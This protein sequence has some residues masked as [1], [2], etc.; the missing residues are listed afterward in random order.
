MDDRKLRRKY[1]F[2]GEGVG[3]CHEGC[4]T[5]LGGRS[6]AYNSA[7]GGYAATAQVL[8][9]MGEL[10]GGRELFLRNARWRSGGFDEEESGQ[11][12]SGQWREGENER[13][14]GAKPKWEAGQLGT[15]P[16]GFFI[17][18]YHSVYTVYVDMFAVIVSPLTSRYQCH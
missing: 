8:V 6:D 9:W 14:A 10:G 1:T 18:T 11:W 13:G 3:A 2:G 15:T 12:A 7:L 4:A 5:R 17:R 16:R